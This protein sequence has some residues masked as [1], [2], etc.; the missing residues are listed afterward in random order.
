MDSMEKCLINESVDIREAIRAIEA[1]QKGIAVI[2]NAN[3][4]LQGVVTDGDVRR[5]LLSGLK[6]K[7]P[8]TL[9]MNRKP[10]KAESRRR[11][12]MPYTPRA[13]PTPS[14]CISI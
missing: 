3:G 10:T 4:C 11:S 13:R 12:S 7:D 1:G 8:V 2:T 5:A 14:S 9:I 6:L